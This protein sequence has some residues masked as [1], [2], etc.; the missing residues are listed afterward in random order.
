MSWAAATARRNWLG[1]ALLVYV[2]GAAP[3]MILNVTTMRYEHD[4]ASGVLLLAIF[5][6]WRLLA[7]PSTPIGRRSIAWLYGTLAVATI[8]AGVLL[9]FG[10]YFKHFEHHNPALLH[11]LQSARSVCPPG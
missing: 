3:F 5:G 10:G 7:A 4:F 1:I 9:G 6:G 8:V 11:A 2:A